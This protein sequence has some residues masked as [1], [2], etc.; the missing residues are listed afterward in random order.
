MNDRDGESAHVAYRWFQVREDATLAGARNM[1][2][3]VD[4]ALHAE[5][6]STSLFNERTVS[7]SGPVPLLSVVWAA[8]RRPEQVMVAGAATAAAVAVAVPAGPTGA[9]VV[10]VSAVT[11]WWQVVRH[12]RGMSEA[13]MRVC[14]ALLGLFT[15]ALAVTVIWLLV[16]LVRTTPAHGWADRRVAVAVAGAV[17]C[18]VTGVAVMV[19]MRMWLSPQRSR[20][21]H[22]CPSPPKRLLAR[23]APECGIYAYRSLALAAHAGCKEQ[24]LARPIVLARVV[25]WGRVYPYTEGF[26]SEW[27]RIETLFDD[28]SGHVEV[29]A[30]HYGAMVEP[31]PPEVVTSGG[32]RRSR[33]RAAGRVA[34]SPGEVA[35][36]AW[37]E[38][39][40]ESRKR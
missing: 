7:R 8:L 37:A 6:V 11:V 24:Q 12:G 9:G 4:E 26:R 3:P 31:L 10:A 23:W 18:A 25:L 32:G 5:H 1:A 38:R 17:L 30:A 29:A 20:R 22:H 15:V 27:A 33:R 34:P 14:A 35:V 21:R 28:G 19:M 39:R 13:L 16:L 36:R 2:W 40:Q